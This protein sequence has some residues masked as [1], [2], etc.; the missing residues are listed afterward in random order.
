MKIRKYFDLN[1]NETPHIYQ[2]LWDAAKTGFIREF[3]TK[4][5]TL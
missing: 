4:M 5:Q 2:N 3:I 1:D